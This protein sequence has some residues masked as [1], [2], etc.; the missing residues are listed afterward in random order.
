MA[1]DIGYFN[2]VPYPLSQE[3]QEEHD[4]RVAIGP[5]VIAKR[6]AH[7]AR[8]DKI[9]TAFTAGYEDTD[10][11][12]YSMSEESLANWLQLATT[13]QQRIEFE[14]ITNDTVIPIY[15]QVGEMVLKPVSE[16]RP[17]LAEI[18]SRAMTIKLQ[19]IYWEG[20]ID[21]YDSLDDVETLETLKT[22][23]EGTTL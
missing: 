22:T 1:E 23:I 21:S 6:N 5:L 13:L 16:V 9:T 3:E 15:T 2:G 7:Q 19:N 20:L 18:G 12:V 8:I 17:L 4:T 11:K 14:S 10:E